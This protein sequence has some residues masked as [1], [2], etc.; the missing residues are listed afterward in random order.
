VIV[1]H[2]IGHQRS[3]AVLIMNRLLTLGGVHNSQPGVA[4]YASVNMDMYPVTVRSTVALGLDH[5][6]YGRFVDVSPN[7]CNSAHH[8]TL[9]KRL[10]FR[11]SRDYW[12]RARLVSGL[13]T[14][15]VTRLSPVF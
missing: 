8:N 2:A 7:S 15:P 4:Q 1:D 13:G 12:P 14:N 6:S 10:E 3:T 9:G 5:T 11:C